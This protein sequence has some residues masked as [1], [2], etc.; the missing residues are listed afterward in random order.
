MQKQFKTIASKFL[1]IA[2]VAATFSTGTAFAQTS[3]KTAH[4][5]QQLVETQRQ[6]S[7]PQIETLTAADK[8]YTESGAA[9]LKAKTNF[10]I[11]KDFGLA[12]FDANSIDEYKEGTDY[13]I[14]DLVYLI[15]RLEGQPEAAQ[16]QKT[17]KAVTGK[18]ATAAQAGKEIEA[19]SKTFLARQNAVQKWY[20]IA[21]QTSVNLKI[22]AYLNE[23]AKTKQGLNDLQSL[24][25]TA[26]PGTSKEMLA[27][28]NALAQYAPKTALTEQD[29]IA[30]FDGAAKVIDA[31]SA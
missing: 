29:Y 8:I 27:T 30:I 16:L 31:G 10:Q 7:A 28:L 23:D 4:V 21:G 3:G 5:L 24:I 11:G 12:A 20:F 17:L 18:T 2:A 26:P 13:T 6:I 9:E 19:A 1:T 15:N 25:T 22:S 14:L